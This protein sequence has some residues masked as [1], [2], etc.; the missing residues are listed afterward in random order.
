[1]E[2][3]LHLPT[4][5]IMK[6]LRGSNESESQGPMAGY[7]FQSRMGSLSLHEADRIRFIGFPDDITNSARAT[8]AHSWPRGIS[9]ERFYAGS[10]EFKLHGRPWD[11]KAESGIFAR[12]LVRNLLASLYSAG[13]V[14]IF[15]TDVS[16]KA[17]DKDTFI[18]RHQSPPP[19]PAEWISIAFSNYNKIRLIDA[20]PD[21]AWALD[22]SISVARAPRPMYEYSPGVAELLLNSF[23]WLAQ[24]S[25]TM[26][27]RQLL[28]QLVLTLEEH[29]FTVY[30][31]VDQKNTYQDD[32]SETDTWHLCR[33]TGWRPGMPVFH[34]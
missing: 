31:S 27:A 9:W 20:P 25:T 1:M 2:K 16:K 7:T 24:G 33:P 8:I 13:W 17:R 14:M 32:R 6:W 26:H 10:Y 21:L 34:R 30:A 15:S 19:P 12:R 4:F 28:L 29:G 5:H 22:R 18:F 3:T 11:G 23:Y